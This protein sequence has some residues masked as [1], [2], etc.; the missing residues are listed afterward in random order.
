MTQATPEP[1]SG[2]A[3]S[4]PVRRPWAVAA[5]AVCVLHVLVLLAL[6]VFYGLELLRGEGSSPT[7]VAMSGVLI[8][9][10]AALLALLARVWFVGSSRGAVPTLVWN[11]L[12]IPV[13]VALY[14]AEE[15]LIATGLL[16]LVVLG[17]VTTAGAL[18]D[19][20]TRPDA[21]LTPRIPLVGRCRAGSPA[22]EPALPATPGQ[23]FPTTA[24]MRAAASVR[25][26]T[27]S[28]V[29]SAVSPPRRHARRTSL[30]KVLTACS[31]SA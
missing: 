12:L 31:R 2:D 1:T 7:T 17:V 10:F 25:M 8:L 29:W 15:S 5:G 24:R 13:V 27:T 19:Q 16:A 30:R 4:R 28:R 18:A 9:V 22:G 23:R 21:D 3:V 11:G 20:A 6:A 14:G 26:S